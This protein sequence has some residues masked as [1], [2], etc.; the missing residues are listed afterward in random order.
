MKQKNSILSEEIQYL[1][2]REVVQTAE[3]AKKFTCSQRTILRRL[4]EVGY[5]KSYNKNGSYITLRDRPGFDENGLWHYKGAFFSKWRT[6]PNTICHLIDTSKAGYTAGE[7]EK[8]LQVELYH[9]LTSC[10]NKA[11]IYCDKRTPRPNYY[12]IDVLKRN[13]QVQNRLEM[14]QQKAIELSKVSRENI[15]KILVVALRHQTANIKKLLPL[16]ELEGVFVNENQV[17]WVFDNYNIK[18]NDSPWNS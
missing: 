17:E 6:I 1:Q 7:I 18:K 16:L 2:V 12:A 9:Q 8:L 5:L 11:K 10:V 3:L 4:K 15:I 13:Q 14:T